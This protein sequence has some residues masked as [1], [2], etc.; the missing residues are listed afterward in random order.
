MAGSV[1]IDKEELI[2][3]RAYALWMAEGQPD[4]RSEDHWQ[5]ARREIDRE[6][7]APERGI[8][9]HSMPAAKKPSR[10]KAG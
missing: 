7:T 1:R 4:G 5:R 2:A 9:E 6:L 8:E 10:R 3:L